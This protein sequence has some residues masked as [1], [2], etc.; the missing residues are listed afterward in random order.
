MS[1]NTWSSDGRGKQKAP[2]TL[3]GREPEGRGSI[4]GEEVPKDRD[5]AKG[6]DEE[7]E[8]EEEEQDVVDDGEETGEQ[9]GREVGEMKLRFQC[10]QGKRCFFSIASICLR[11]CPGL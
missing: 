1:A 8:E 10:Q 4:S 5:D 6:E 2:V 7:E 11:S 9:L 3:S